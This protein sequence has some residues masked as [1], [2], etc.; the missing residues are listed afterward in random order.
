MDRIPRTKNPNRGTMHAWFLPLAILAVV[1]C[2]N[3]LPSKPALGSNSATALAHS[4][5]R[6]AAAL[7]SNGS[8][9]PAGLVPVTYAGQSI[10]IWPYTGESLNGVPSDPINLVFV[11][12]ADPVQIRAALLALDGD[13]TAFGFPPVAPFNA[14]WKDGDGG[15]Q[16]AYSSEGGW[17]GGVIQL[18]LGEY[19]PVR[20]H[21]RLFRTDVPFGDGGSWTLG[22]AHF[23]V[24]IPGTT[25]H[26]VLSWELAQQIV[27]VD[28]MRSGL[29]VAS[30]PA[31]TG[32]IN[33]APSFREIPD[34]IYNQLPP[35]LVAAIQG[36]AQPVPGAVPLASDGQATILHLATAPAVAPG[37]ETETFT[38]EFGQ[39]IPKPLCSDGPLDWVHVS[40]PVS[41]EKMAGVDEAGRYRYR[42]RVS[43]RLTV[44]PVDITT[45][46][47]T[48]AGEPYEAMIS[49]AQ[50]GFLGE[51]T[52]MVASRSRR[53]AP[54]QGGTEILLSD[55][56]VGSPG[57]EL[58]RITS[59]CLQPAP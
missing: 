32:A 3:E 21:L 8:T 37:T 1:G 44:T 33:Q 54:Q 11:G 34:F 14:R 6:P 58:H 22:G 49:E 10:A 12:H 40:G 41:F 46:P 15:V 13:R 42:S 28:L 48:P 26:Q 25:E 50:E 52:Q 16:T 57:T 53:L 59:E 4:A 20:T 24:L 23:E 45:Q 27:T 9:P 47:P 29:L 38:I 30:G 31:S 56:R 17:T 35:E 18:V 51:A 55:L 7:V 5:A 39:V 36:P 2:S 19:G 43:G